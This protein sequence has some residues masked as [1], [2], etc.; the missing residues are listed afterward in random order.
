[1]SP[2]LTGAQALSLPCNHLLDYFTLQDVKICLCLVPK[3][4]MLG[5]SALTGTQALAFS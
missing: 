5:P 4:S 3:E 1:M 2:A